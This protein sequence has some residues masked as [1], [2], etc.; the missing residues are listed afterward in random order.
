VFVLRS[1]EDIAYRVGVLVDASLCYFSFRGLI[2][3]PDDIRRFL[4]SFLFLVIPFVLCV[5]FETLKSQNPFELLGKFDPA[6]YTRNGRQRA[7]GSF[8][9]PSLVGTVGAAFVPLY[10][11]L[12]YRASARKIAIVGIGLCLVI[13]WA[14]NSGAPISCLLFAAVGWFF[15]RIRTKMQLVRRIVVGSIVVLALV[16]KSPIWYLPTHLSDFTG[17]DGYHRSYLLDIAFQNV[18]KWGLAGMPLEETADWFPTQLAWGVADMTDQYISFGVTAGLGAMALFIAIF[19]RGFSRLGRAMNAV[20]LAIGSPSE[21]EFLLWGLG[22]VLLVHA[23][24]LFGI[25]YY[26]QS[27]ALWYMHLAMISGMSELYFKNP[28]FGL[29]ESA[30]FADP[31]IELQRPL[32][33]GE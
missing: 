7:F 23:G 20:R 33:A 10:L 18:R 30:Q 32:G 29:E 21:A 28:R 14:A 3:E 1:H 17:G 15:W 6:G 25:S 22:V 31:I 11:A 16:M 8:M 13:V 27:F 2:Q 12:G 24:N 4:K 5:S 26:D 9:H 19:V